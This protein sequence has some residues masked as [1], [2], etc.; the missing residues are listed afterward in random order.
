MP[1]AADDILYSVLLNSLSRGRRRCYR[2]CKQLRC[3]GPSDGRV[4]AGWVSCIL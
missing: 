3:D 4:C 2:V 1:S